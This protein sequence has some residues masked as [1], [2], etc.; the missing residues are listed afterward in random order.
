MPLVVRGSWSAGAVSVSKNGIVRVA[1]VRH[2]GRSSIVPFG[3]YRVAAV[4]LLTEIVEN[5]PAQ[6]LEKVPTQLYATL[7]VWFN[8]YKH[9]NLYHNLFFRLVVAIVRS[10]QEAALQ[11]LLGDCKLITSLIHHWRNRNSSTDKTSAGGVV[12]ACLNVIRLQAQA[13]KPDAYLR[14]FIGTHQLWN[15]FLPELLVRRSCCHRRWLR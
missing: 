10:S 8:L 3:S 15:E 7:I 9:T 2:P 13:I 1:A 11:A 6:A 5:D 14:N 12:L 4:Q